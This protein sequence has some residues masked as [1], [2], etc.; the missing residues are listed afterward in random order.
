MTTNATTLTVE[1]LE[2]RER[3][4][5]LGR[6]EFAPYAAQWDETATYPERSL[7]VLK[8]HG[9]IGMCVSEEY[10]GQGKGVLEASL[11]IEGVAHGCMATAMMLQGNLNGPSRVIAEIGTPQQRAKYLPGVADGSHSFA[12][13]MTEPQAGSDGLALQTTLTPVDGGF[14]LSGEKSH[15]TSGDHSD[16]ILVFCRA[17]GTVGPRGIGAVLV[18]KDDPGFEVVSIEKKMGSRGINETVLR[19]SDI[20]IDNDDVV[21]APDPESNNGAAFLVKQFNPER[22]GNAAMTLGVA[23]SAFEYA[24]EYAKNREQFG[25]PIAEFQGM[26]WRIADMAV[27]LDAARLMLWRAAGSDVDG[28]PPIRE[29]AMAKL[30]CNETA[31]KVCNEAIGMLGHKGYLTEHPLERNFRDVRGMAIA[32]G[33]VDILRNMIGAEVTGMRISQRRAS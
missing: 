33:S 20:F 8:E 9:F 30:L 11:A 13:A 12:I 15:I 5:E 32:G 4:I 1:Q 29:T 6:T 28:F 3:A 10:G 27:S 31:I 14:Q 21:L 19:F 7:A 23:Q 17:P 25:R 22:C 24:V 2:L 26:Q 18:E 16:T